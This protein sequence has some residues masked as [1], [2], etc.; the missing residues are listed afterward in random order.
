VIAG[1]DL[2]GTQLRVA[3]AR[4]DGQIVAVVKTATPRVASPEQMVAWVASHVERLRQGR[5]VNGAAV[6][7]PGPIDQR[8]GVLV[9]P[10]NLP[11]WKNVALGRMLSEQ[12]G[13][14]V[15]LENDANLAGLGEFKRGAGSGSQT[16]VYVTWSTGVG[17]GLIVDG[18]LL[19]G[20][21]GSAGEAGHMIIDPDGPLD[22]CGQHGCVEAFC[23]GHMLERQTGRPA[24]EIFT[25]AEAGEPESLMIV[26]RA[27]S[28]MGLALINLANLIDPEVIVIGGGISR[29]WKLIR[30]LL[31]QSIRSSPFIR[32]ERRPRLRRARLGDRAGYVGAIEW[33][34][35]N[36]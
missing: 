33:A 20:G 16:M 17:S 27:S 29:S 4:S 30:P 1:I 14:P 13:A 35:A 11:G 10:P 31:E 21:H 32:P 5:K 22:S 9:N 34:R 26:R 24:A 28:Y 19:R 15:L 2:G 12:I 7:A 18:R 36:L 23:G 6:G 3:V 25:A 8:T